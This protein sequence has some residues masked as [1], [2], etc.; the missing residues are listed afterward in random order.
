[1]T[2]SELDSLK[3][4]DELFTTLYNAQGSVY[5]AIWF[6]GRTDYQFVL[7]RRIEGGVEFFLSTEELLSENWGL[8]AG[9]K[10]GKVFDQELEELLDEK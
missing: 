8:A 2:P 1:M 9:T 4:G 7:V 5:T 3:I 6:G 10:A